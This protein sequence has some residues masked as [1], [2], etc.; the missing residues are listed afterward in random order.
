MDIYSELI[1]IYNQLEKEL[2]SL[3]Q[4]CNRCGTC[5]NFTTFDHIL[6]ASNIEVAYIKQH[7]KIPD[8][9]ISDNICPFLKNNQC[10]IREYRTLGCRVFYCN[11][12]YK[13]ITSEIYEKY[14]RMIRELSMKYSVQWEYQPF[15]TQLA[16]MKQP[17]A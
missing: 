10:S 14:Y 11:H 16:T 2:T 3:D 8:F 17:L 12:S 5:C 1:T 15:L 7:K 4:V 9:T 6:Y 13:E